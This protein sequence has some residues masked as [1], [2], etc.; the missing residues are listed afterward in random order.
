MTVTAS[1]KGGAGEIW[2]VLLWQ[3]EISWPIQM[4]HISFYN[5]LDY[6]Q[7]L[8]TD[9]MQTLSPCLLHMPTDDFENLIP[10]RTWRVQMWRG[11]KRE[12]QINPNFISV[13]QGKYWIHVFHCCRIDQAHQ[14][15]QLPNIVLVLPLLAKTSS[16]AVLW[17][18]APS[19]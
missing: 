17:Y 5:H 1:S 10:Q 19:C 14:C 6:I 7:G 4:V 13:S 9:L 18:L 16:E 12:P 15:D 8:Q 3:A 11:W 2:Q